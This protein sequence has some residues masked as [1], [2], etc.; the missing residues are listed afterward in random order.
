MNNRVALVTG[1]SSGIGAATARALAA[2]GFTTYAAARRTKAMDELKAHGIIVLALDV[3]SPHS[4]A[5]CLAAIRERDGEVDVLVNNAGYGAYGAVE[6]VPME[7]A[8]RQFEV[9]LFGV[10][11]LTQQVIP[12][13]R[14]QRWGRIINVSSTGGVATTPYGAWYHSSKFALEGYSSALRQ[15]LAPFGVGVALIRPSGTK[16]EWGSIATASLLQTSGHG[17]YAEGVAHMGEMFS[18]TATAA[19][20]NP[21]QVPASVIASMIVTAATAKTAKSA[22]N[23]PGAGKISVFLRWLLSDRLHDAMVRAVFKLPRTMGQYRSPL[24]GVV[25]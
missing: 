16:S 7:E 9:N 3:T 6:E 4:V 23:A 11:A 8:R 19:E 12:H 15:E 18:K 17:P 22:Y 1:A 10:A 5:A 24:E 13:M 2:A 14:A 20:G 25:Q 21:L